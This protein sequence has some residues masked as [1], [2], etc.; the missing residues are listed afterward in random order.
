M[1]KYGSEAP[2]GESAVFKLVK[3]NCTAVKHQEVNQR[4]FPEERG[5]EVAR[6]GRRWLAKEQST[7][8]SLE[9]GK[10]D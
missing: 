1:S 6:A 9:S 5:G 3:Y 10:E 2:S 7:Q 4:S 8:D